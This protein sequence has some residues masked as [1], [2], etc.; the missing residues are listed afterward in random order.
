MV[1]NGHG[2]KLALKQGILIG[3][4]NIRMVPTLMLIQ[5]VKIREKSIMGMIILNKEKEI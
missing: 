2:I 1:M 4:Y 5:K 3:M